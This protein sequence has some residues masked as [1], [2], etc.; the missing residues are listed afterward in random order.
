MSFV[1]IFTPSSYNLALLPAVF[2]CLDS[3]AYLHII[4][5][6]MEVPYGRNDILQKES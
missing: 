4:A 3:I 5:N 1:S 6:V 2:K